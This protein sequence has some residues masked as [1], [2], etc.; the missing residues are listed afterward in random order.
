MRTKYNLLIKSLSNILSIKIISFFQRLFDHLM[1]IGNDDVKNEVKHLTKILNKDAKFI[2]DIGAGHGAYTEELLTKYPDAYFFL[3]EPQKI[4]YNYLLK[5]FKNNKKVKIYNLAIS[6]KITSTNL[7]FDKK[8]SGLASLVKRNLKHHSTKFNKKEKV[9]TTTL[10]SFFN[11]K[12]NKKNLKISLCKL[13]IEG[14]E[15]SV[16]NSIKKIFDKF[17]VIQFE[18]GGCNIDSRTYFKDYW[19]TLKDNFLIYR[20]CPNRL[21]LIQE[22]SEK[23]E[24]FNLTNYLAINK[25]YKF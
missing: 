25:K 6:N 19:L 15:L 20:I 10:V 2:F 7:Y 3:F 8:G 24:R 1:G 4:C 14:H 11:D 13:D 9:K 5:K 23:E 17:N 16:L 18:F 21:L 22:Y 12:F